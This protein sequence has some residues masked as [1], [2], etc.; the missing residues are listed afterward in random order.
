[1]L[2]VPQIV[3]DVQEISTV[4]DSVKASAG[5]SEHV[6]DL[7]RGVMLSA[8]VGQAVGVDRTT[9]TMCHKCAP[10]PV[11]PKCAVCGNQIKNA[12]L[13]L[14]PPDFI[15]AVSHFTATHDHRC[16][17]IGYVESFGIVILP[18]GNEQITEA[19]SGPFVESSGNS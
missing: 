11:L 6:I 3:A 13:S 15:S 16:P 2:N 17:A 18:P 7:I 1:M 5:L 14:L 8:V 9:P 4:L 12:I 10:E 19:P